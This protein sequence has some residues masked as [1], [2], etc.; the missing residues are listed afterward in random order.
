M[1]DEDYELLPQKEILKLKKDISKLRGKA[2]PEVLEEDRTERIL[3]TMEKLSDSIENLNDIFNSTAE[4]IKL[5]ERSEDLYMKKLEPLF[6]KVNKL[7]EQNEK[8]AKGMVALADMV[9]EQK[10]AMEDIEQSRREKRHEEHQKTV[11]NPMSMPKMPP[12]MRQSPMPPPPPM[13]P[14]P[15]RA[16][17][18]PQPPM[19]GGMPP[20]PGLRPSPMPMQ[21]S[22]MPPPDIDINIAPSPGER[23]QGGGGFL[24]K[25]IKIKK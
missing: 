17:P 15:H 19:R 4:D 14:M 21:R 3:D 24:S 5:E 13:M 10:A 25:F 18:I 23:K 8:I 12:Q 20:P 11:V 7:I 9:N 16:A 1:V 2:P 6:D 22:A